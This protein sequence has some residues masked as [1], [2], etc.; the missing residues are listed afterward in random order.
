MIG[1]VICTHATLSEALLEATE[2]IVGPM[3]KTKT[4]C[5]QPGDSGEI[6]VDRLSDAMKAVDSGAGVIILCD[7]FGGT[8][9]N[10]SLSLLG[11]EVEIV[12]GVN[13]NALKL[14][15]CRSLP[16]PK[17]RQAFRAMVVTTS[18][19]PVPSPNLDRMKSEY[20]LSSR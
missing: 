15:T 17:L 1:V 10:V 16:W 12:T 4:V 9:S 5:V 3:E 13:F 19:L 6:I 8:P 11:D 20:L 14:T 2:M 18:W 7:M